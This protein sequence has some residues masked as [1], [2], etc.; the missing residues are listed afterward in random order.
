MHASHPDLGLYCEQAV[1]SCPTCQRVKTRHRH[2]SEL[3]AR[4]VRGNPWADIAVDLIG[5][6]KV[7]IHHQE[8][9]FQALTVIDTVTNLCEL[10][11]ITDKTACHV[12]LQLENAW[13][14][15]YPR[16][17]RC[18]FDQ[19]GEFIG[20]GFAQVLRNHGIKPV[21]LTAKNPQSNLI[22][23]RLHPT[24]GNVPRAIAHYDAPHDVPS[25][26]LMVDTALQTA[27]YSART[28]IHGSLK[29]SPGSL[30]FHR[31]M[32]FDLPL[33]VNMEM[34]RLY[35]QQIVDERARH[36]NRSCIFHDYSVGDQVLLRATNPDKLDLRTSP[37]PFLVT[38]VHTNGT[39]TIQRGP[40]VTERINVRRL[41][42]YRG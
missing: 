34:V 2:Y 4:E 25:A 26:T 8:L 33:I 21:P 18:L 7:S 14:S 32:L 13:L 19:G 3:P 15:R 6:W 10:I 35:R 24:V 16:P 38:R 1:T 36:A 23:E 40:H 30:A 28:A 9:T 11:R 17:V 5:P 31:D 42:P 29:H 27:A 12:G 41:L 39:V 22:C 37:N 20:Q